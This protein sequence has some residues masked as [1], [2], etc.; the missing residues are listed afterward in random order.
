MQNREKR[1]LNYL[2]YMRAIGILLIVMQ[3][4]F[5]YF[6]VYHKIV[7]YI[8]GFHVT[9]F[10]VISGCLSGIKDEDACELKKMV[11]N[12]AKSLIIPY[13]IFSLI[14]IFLK[15]TVLGIQHG[16]T[17][18][19]VKQ[20]ITEFFITGNGTVWFLTTLFLVEILFY[21]L[22]GKHKNIIYGLTGVITGGVPFFM[23]QDSMPLGIVLRRTMVG[24]AF[25]VWGY[26]LGKYFLQRIRYKM[27]VG[28]ILLGAGFIIWN[29]W[30][31]EMSYFSGNFQGM[32]PA[33][34]VNICSVSGILLLLYL[35]DG[36]MNR[37]IRLLSYFG[38]NS[39]IIM[40]AHP[41]LLMCYIYPFGYKIANYSEQIQWIAGMIL[42]LTLIVLEI[43]AIELIQRYFP[44]LIGKKKVKI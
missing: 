24:Y 7:S 5:Q 1:R 29:K 4:A 15:V 21:L 38:K 41:I 40:V 28:M 42:Y 37:K 30:S 31:F 18:E 33:I 6:G 39:L 11:I 25:L 19:I 36:K 32:I 2:D 17:K 22:K 26:F 27:I 10:F 43:P 12:R 44:F 34:L 13:M 9:I 23:S 14:N 8:K 20:E 16:F 35:L 3:H